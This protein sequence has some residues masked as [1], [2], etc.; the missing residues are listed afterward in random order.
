MRVVA[1]AVSLI[2]LSVGCFASDWNVD[3][4]YLLDVTNSM[5]GYCASGECPENAHNLETAVSLLASEI[6]NYEG[7]HFILTVF[8]GNPSALSSC[9]GPVDLDGDGPLQSTYDLHISS[10]PNDPKRMWLLSFLDPDT[11]LPEGEEFTDEDGSPYPSGKWGEW[12]GVVAA[13]RDSGRGGTTTDIYDNLDAALDKLEELE[14]SG[15]ANYAETH[16]Q[17]IVLITDGENVCSEVSKE[18]IEKRLAARDSDVFQSGFLLTK[19][20]L[21]KDCGQPPVDGRAIYRINLDRQGFRFPGNAWLDTAFDLDGITIPSITIGTTRGDVTA[22]VDWG[23]AVLD[24]AR[25]SLTVVGAAGNLVPLRDVGASLTPPRLNPS[26]GIGPGTKFDLQVTL[27]PREALRDAIR[28]AGSVEGTIVGNLSL[29]YEPQESEGR[30]VGFANSAPR[31]T[32]R[33]ERPN[34]LVSLRDTVDGFDLVLTPNAAFRTWAADEGKNES[35]VVDFDR[36]VFGCVDLRGNE[37]SGS[38]GCAALTAETVLHFSPRVAEPGTSV[39]EFRVRCT[40]AAGAALFNG[41]ADWGS[42]RVSVSLIGLDGP[43]FRVSENLWD[44]PLAHV[45]GVAVIARIKLIGTPEDWDAARLGVVPVGFPCRVQATLNPDRQGTVTVKLDFPDVSELGPRRTTDPTP[46][47]YLQFSYSRADGAP[48]RLVA[49]LIPKVPVFLTN[50]KRL[51][52]VAPSRQLSRACSGDEVEAD[53]GVVATLTLS[54]EDPNVG[55]QYQAVT[56]SLLDDNPFVLALA[57]SDATAEEMVRRAGDGV[58][59]KV[60]PHTAVGERRGALEVTAAEGAY[61]QVGDSSSVGRSARIEW[62]VTLVRTSHVFVDPTPLALANPWVASDTPAGWRM[63][64][65][66]GNITFLPPTSGRL[67]EAGALQ[68]TVAPGSTGLPDRLIAVETPKEISPPFVGVKGPVQLTLDLAEMRRSI[69]VERES[70]SGE[71]ELS[72]RGSEKVRFEMPDGGLAQT[73]TIPFTIDT[74]RPWIRSVEQT[75]HDG[76]ERNRGDALLGFAID[77]A[78]WI[79]KAKRQVTAECACP[80]VRVDFSDDNT[81]ATLV[82]AAD[83]PLGVVSGTI[84]FRSPDPDWIVYGAERSF[85]YTRSGR[86]T[87]LADPSEV[88]GARVPRGRTLGTLTLSPGLDFGLVPEPAREL[89]VV[90]HDSQGYEIKRR[91]DGNWGDEPSSVAIEDA[92]GRQYRSGDWLPLTPD[93]LAK[94]FKIVPAPRIAYGKHEGTLTLSYPADSPLRLDPFEWEFQFRLISWVGIIMA[95]VGKGAVLLGMCCL[96]A[97]VGMLL[98]LSISRRTPPLRTLAKVLRG[99]RRVL[100]QR[101]GFLCI[102][103]LLFGAVLWSVAAFAFGG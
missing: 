71:L 8:A 7:G 63:V 33:F 4:V 31:F 100:L 69:D 11:Y 98:W 43:D 47:G 75:N 86:I 3:G 28:A 30:Y 88:D 5:I 53:T 101:A 16:V 35:V 27:S 22:V 20:C 57:G 42:G 56:L 17:R 50:E 2:V 93:V 23:E 85:R 97:G 32:V 39:G 73:A 34:V 61:V 13:V 46:A 68:V 15:G 36:G 12:R 40:A 87:A 96:L 62:C 38:I 1:V 9:T 78:P 51:V 10:D 41:A 29:T 37:H 82:L 54:A 95:A 92:N 44:P 18:K 90:E 21:S 60:A 103:L 6:K 77:Y 52:H 66:T 72:Y 49:F 64:E 70:I 67:A 80:G 19:Y 14:L 89:Q 91:A 99:P 81:R 79:P 45:P 55:A 59:L 84:A 58:E 25:S 24:I 65:S 94:P 26:G 74:R 83:G 76:Q 102:G 48:H